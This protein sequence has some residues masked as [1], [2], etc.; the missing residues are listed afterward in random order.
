MSVGENKLDVFNVGE[1]IKSAINAVFTEYDEDLPAKQYIYAGETP[2]HDCEQLT[3]G[4]IQIYSGAPGEQAQSESKC[5]S[6]RTATFRVELVRGCAPGLEQVQDADTQ[7][8]YSSRIQAPSAETF[9]GDARRKLVDAT[10]LM[11][12]GMRVAGNGFI[13][14]MADVQVGPVSGGYQAMILNV[15]SVIE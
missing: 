5:N 10:L 7:R 4:F 1:N 6:P 13:G 9:E 14:G 2:T 3:I 8:R 15:I 12:A 11:E